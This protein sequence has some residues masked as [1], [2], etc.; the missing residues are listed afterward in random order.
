[1]SPNGRAS[2]RPFVFPATDRNGHIGRQLSGAILRLSIDQ[3]AE[4]G[5]VARALLVLLFEEFFI[6]LF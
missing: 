4:G 6:K 3:G 1:M 2:V 5:V